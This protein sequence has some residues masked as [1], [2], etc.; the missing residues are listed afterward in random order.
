MS[1][2]ETSTQLSSASLLAR[3]GKRPSSAGPPIDVGSNTDMA[4]PRDPI[5]RTRGIKSTPK[6]E[7]LIALQDSS[8]SRDS[9]N[10]IALD[11][12]PPSTATAT[13][14]FLDHHPSTF[15]D[16]DLAQM[17]EDFGILESIILTLLQLSFKPIA[18]DPGEIALSRRYLELNLR[19]PIQ[20]CLV[21]VLSGVELAPMQ[22]N[23]TS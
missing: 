15:I 20:P 13:P 12:S 8:S 2:Q 3:K 23:A 14:F 4:K 22:L 6:S 1:E 5:Q 9:S 18:P 17:R 16:S 10:N 19:L 21:K 7:A 11:D